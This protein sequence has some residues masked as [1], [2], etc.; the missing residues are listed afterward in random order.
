MMQDEGRV[1]GGVVEVPHA[2]LLAA[3]QPQVHGIVGNLE[4]DLEDG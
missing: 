1:V 4:L 2:V 3:S